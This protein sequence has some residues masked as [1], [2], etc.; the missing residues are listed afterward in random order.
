MAKYTA[1]IIAQSDVSGTVSV[2]G[3]GEASSKRVAAQRAVERLFAEDRIKDGG[4]D[5]F[6]SSLALYV[7]DAYPNEARIVERVKERRMRDLQD[8]VAPVGDDP[9]PALRPF[10]GG[11]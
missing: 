5:T 10:R 4:G 9:A 6:Y 3:R 11:R 8:T 7:T 1:L 2:R